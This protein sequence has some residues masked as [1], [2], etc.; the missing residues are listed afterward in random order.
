MTATS[1]RWPVRPAR[2]APSPLEVI[3]LVVAGSSVTI[4]WAVL[5]SHGGAAEFWPR[6]VWFGL[7]VVLAGRV[8]LGRAHSVPPG[9]RRWLA[10][11]AA[12]FSVIAPL[13][14][15][16][17]LLSGGGFFWPV[18][19]LLGFSAL[20]A[21][22]A[23]AVSRISPEREAQLS[24]RVVS[25]MRSRRTAVEEEAARVNRIERDLHDGAQARLVSLTVGLGLAEELVRTDPAAAAELLAESRATAGAALE[26]I[27]TVMAGIRP[28][29]LAD[30]GLEGALE[31]LAVDLS[32]PVAVDAVG[33]APLSPA[34]ES[35]VYFVVA[36]CLANV[37]KHSGASSARVALCVA[38]GVL[39]VE[40]S[41]D[42][43][44]GAW[45]GGGSGLRGAVARLEPFDGTLA[46][47]SPLGGP[48]TVTVRVPTD[49]GT[50]GAP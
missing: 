1:Q 44:G 4:V 42:G 2:P 43:V 28:P 34:L 30:R 13:D 32:V 24:S 14:V 33:L 27:R 31:A 22:H 47:T 40:V 8:A 45:V 48:T 17:W 41:D 18:F 21:A 46:L 26:D 36:E 6:W 12:V 37:V 16:V 15:T 19:P 23:W 5:R 9:R 11:H 50:A 35:A 25:L 20:L 7:A 38:D 29:V 49:P 10:R 39:T 3:V